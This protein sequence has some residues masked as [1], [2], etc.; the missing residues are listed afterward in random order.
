MKVF[1]YL[2]FFSLFVSSLANADVFLELSPAQINIDTPSLTSRPFVA[3][4]RLGYAE[5]NQQFELAFMSH[6][7]D[8]NE[9]SL[10]I[11]VP[12]VFS[13]FY[14]YLPN[15]QTSLKYHLIIGASYIEVDTSYPQV[16]NSSDNF[17]G[18]S[19]GIGFEESFKSAPQVKL[20]FDVIQ[21]YRGDQLN[22]NA[23]SLGV[24]YEF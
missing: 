19:Y 3:D 14:H 7:K 21:L 12:A 9:N 22:I 1:K 20:S 13:F 5:Y 15:P 10:S 8:D 6:I 11:E 18:V 23:V 16:S 4:I 24:H 2:L 17:Y